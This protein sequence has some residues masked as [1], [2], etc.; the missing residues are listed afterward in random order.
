VTAREDQN[1]C[2][3]A[4]GPQAGRDFDEVLRQALHT[5]ADAIEPADDGLTRI[6]HRLNTPSA[7]RHVALLVTD[8]V[9]LARLVTIWLEPAFTWAM[10]LRRRHHTG[11]RRVSSHRATGAPSR[12][13]APWLRPALAVVGAAAIVVT[14]VVVLGPMRQL[15]IQTSVNT[16]PGAS[17]P[18]HAGAHS[19]GASHRQSPATS[20][21]QTA[22]AQSGTA[23]AHAGRATP[24]PSP[25]ITP[26]GTPAASPS[27]TLGPT[28]T[29]SKTN[30][31]QPKPHPSKTKSPP[32]QA[33][34]G[35]S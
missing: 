29:P 25:K 11:Y 1:W 7:V 17:T 18:A 14:G 32:G 24:K 12:P 13:A 15:V 2:D 30:H 26:S 4:R 5:V 33:K 16:S 19:A 22:P 21:P 31:G 28:P 10:R 6:M 3:P 35:G 27:Q 8:C 23:S 34:K 20:F 9:D